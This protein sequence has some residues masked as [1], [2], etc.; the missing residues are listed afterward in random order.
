MLK[1]KNVTLLKPK[2]EKRREFLPKL[3]KE[4]SFLSNASNFRSLALILI[5]LWSFSPHNL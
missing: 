5:E 2:I 1:V 4:S 3:Q